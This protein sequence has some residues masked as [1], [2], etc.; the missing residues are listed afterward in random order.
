V[1]LPALVSL[2]IVHFK[3]KLT[4]SHQCARSELFSFGEITELLISL[5]VLYNTLG[6]SSDAIH[7]D[8]IVANELSIILGDHDDQFVFVS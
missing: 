2:S 4:G 8:T 1:A 5:H 7:T 3:L 6:L